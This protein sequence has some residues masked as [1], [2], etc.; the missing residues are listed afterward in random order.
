MKVYRPNPA[1]PRY[2]VKRPKRTSPVSMVAALPPNCSP[3][4]RNIR[5]RSGSE[6]TETCNARRPRADALNTTTYLQTETTKRARPSARQGK[7]GRHWKSCVE[8]SSATDCAHSPTT[9]SPGY[10]HL[11]SDARRAS[12]GMPSV[13]ELVPREGDRSTTL[14]A[15]RQSWHRCDE[16]HIPPTETSPQWSAE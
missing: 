6:A 9:P 16:Y 13:V 2:R 3:V 7:A 14:P 15:A 4:F 1:N 11:E 10:R 12:I 8:A 5:P